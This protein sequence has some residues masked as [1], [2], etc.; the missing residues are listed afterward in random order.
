MKAL[1][2]RSFSFGGG[3]LTRREEVGWLAR[4]LDPTN[5]W[6]YFS[7]PTFERWELLV[8]IVF[9]TWMKINWNMETPKNTWNPG[10]GIEL[11][12]EFKDSS[13]TKTTAIASPG[14]SLGR[15]Q[16][17]ESEWF[18]WPRSS[19]KFYKICP[20]CSL[21]SVTLILV[22]VVGKQYTL[23]SYEMLQVIWC[24]PPLRRA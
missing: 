16:S 13:L 18:D 4:L 20:V 19:A 15:Y 23:L 21:W 6:V 2:Y 10:K 11:K 24:K 1:L 22:S 9:W 5:L 3:V 8:R 12:N 7:W 17:H 14:W